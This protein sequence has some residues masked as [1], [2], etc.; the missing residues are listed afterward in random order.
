MLACELH[1]S[2]KQLLEDTS[3]DVLDAMVDY[4]ETRAQEEQRARRMADLRSRIG[5]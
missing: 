2:E 5:N 3:P 1:M 4:L